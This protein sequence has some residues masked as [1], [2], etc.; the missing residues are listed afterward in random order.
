MTTR[1]G[2]PTWLVRVL[3][4]C[5]LL[6][7]T[8]TTGM[9]ATTYVVDRVVGTGRIGGQIQTNGKAGVLT[10]SDIVDWNLTIDADGDSAT[11]GQLLGPLSG[12]NSTVSLLNGDALTATPEAISFDFSGSGVLQITKPDFSVTWQLQAGIFSDEQVGGHRSFKPS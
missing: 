8:S 4:A 6:A 12:A 7:A 3:G 11:T 1:G 5:A 10:A 2:T 9:A